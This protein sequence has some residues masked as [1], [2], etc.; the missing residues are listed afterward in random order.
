MLELEALDGLANSKCSADLNE[1]E[2]SDKESI[3]TSSEKSSSS[4]TCNLW[5]RN[6]TRLELR[7]PG[8][9][10]PRRQTPCGCEL[11]GANKTS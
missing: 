3:P 5:T 6:K 4:S 2:N 1:S 8:N 11:A 7:E 10:S 9:G